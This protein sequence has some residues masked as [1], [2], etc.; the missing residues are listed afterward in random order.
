MS[1]NVLLQ[2]IPRLATKIVTFDG[3]I[4]AVGDLDVFN[5]TGRC[6]IQHLAV[7]CSQTLVATASS[8]MSLGMPTNDQEFLPDTDQDA[9]NAGGWWDGTTPNNQAGNAI[10]DKTCGPAS[11]TNV[12][13][14]ILNIETSAITAGVMEIFLLWLPLS[15]D[16]FISAT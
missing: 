1:G 13:T 4:G 8:K 10:T 11:S 9:L 5:V 7:G 12:N 16:G 2:R 14:I 15:G 3:T 6:L